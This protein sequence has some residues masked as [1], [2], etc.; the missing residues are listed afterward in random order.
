[1]DTKNF[2]HNY[3]DFHL[4]DTILSKDDM[5]VLSDYCFREDSSVAPFLS[6]PITKKCNF[7]CA[8][9]GVGGEATSSCS[10][11]FSIEKIIE[12]SS[13]GIKQG[14]TKFRLTGG[15][16]FMHK[17]I[18]S[19]L[20]YFS[21][22]GYYTLVNTNGSLIVRNAE[23]IEQLNQNIRFAVSLDTLDSSKLSRIS[24]FGNLSIILKGLELL[25][26]RGLLLRCNMVVG[27]HNIDE[28]QS[29]ICLCQRLNCDLK[30]L[31][32]VSVPVPYGNRTNLYQEV[33]SLE[34][35]LL[36]TCDEVF[37][38]EYTRHFGTPCYRYRFGNTFVTVKN[39]QKGS[40]YDL[41]EGGLCENCKYFPCH[42]GLYDI[43][44]LADGRLCSCRWTES[45][46]SS[47]SATQMKFLI[48][49]F[50]RSRYHA[51][52]GNSNMEVRTDLV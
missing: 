45:Q 52:P 13:L 46:A 25:A 20:N 19:I 30:I 43:F 23:I 41:G 3:I 36:A 17:E 21:D 50:R 34:K 14:I 24:R 16:P 27:N 29:I 22:L 9:C 28:V 12:L 7:K 51:K 6:F 39:S 11:Q 35:H 4:R 1:M 31:D 32:I 42:E 5:T 40:H 2:R 49:A 44:A 8:Y 18:G 10:D 38:H 33:N 48:D 26:E 37:S 15:E 47:N